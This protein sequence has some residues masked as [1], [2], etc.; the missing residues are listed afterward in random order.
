MAMWRPLFDVPPW[1]SMYRFARALQ[2][3]AVAPM[4]TEPVE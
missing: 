4:P 3:V 1:S 2:M